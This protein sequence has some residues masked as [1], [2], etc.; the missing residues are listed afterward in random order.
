MNCTLIVPAN[1][2]S[3]QGLATPYKLVATDPNA[4]ACNEANA[5]Q[6]A[7]VQGVIYDPSKGAFS[8]Y[9]PLII[10]KGTKPALAP[11]PPTLPAGAVVG[12]WFGFDANNLL[13]QG[14]QGNTLA[15]A[16]CVNGLGQSLFTQFA[17]CNAHSFLRGRQPGGCHTSR[18]Y[19]R[20][21][22]SERWYD[23]PD[24]AR[25]QRGGPGPER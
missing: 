1:P 10:D 8:V 4:G 18:A 19:S 21:G 14:A 17:S 13:L 20:P 3:A 24:R 23:L 7:F 25:F 6:S 12:L 16:H 15:Q 2:L 11:T 5:A 22:K 9:N